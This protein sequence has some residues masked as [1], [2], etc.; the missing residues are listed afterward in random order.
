VFAQ[1]LTSNILKNFATVIFGVGSDAA[2]AVSTALSCVATET[3]SILD[4]KETEFTPERLEIIKLTNEMI[5]SQPGGP[6][7]KESNNNKNDNEAEKF[8]LSHLK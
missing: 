3:T 6:L 2:Q 4:D 1:L 8:F 5:Q 7:I